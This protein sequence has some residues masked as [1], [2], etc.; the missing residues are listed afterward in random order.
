MEGEGRFRL[1]NPKIFRTWFFFCDPRCIDS[2]CG[3]RHL[4]T[5]PFV[6]DSH[7]CHPFWIEGSSG[8]N[9][10]PTQLHRH[11]EGGWCWVLTSIDW[12]SRECAVPLDEVMNDDVRTIFS[13]FGQCS[14]R[15][16]IELDVSLV[17]YVEQIQKSLIW[18]TNYEEIRALLDSPHED[19]NLV[20]MWCAMVHKEILMH[21]A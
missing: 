21:R 11:T 9:Q 8:S 16:T 13:I 1:Y 15:G 17:R 18:S 19:S 2:F 7:S 3:P 10:P 12:L 5:T 4:E 6:Q 14:T 20:D